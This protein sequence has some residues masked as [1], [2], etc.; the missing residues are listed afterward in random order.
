MLIGVRTVSPEERPRKSRAHHML[1]DWSRYRRADTTKMQPNMT[2]TQARHELVTLDLPEFFLELFDGAATLHGLGLDKPEKGLLWVSE[3]A[4]ASFTP[5]FE[6]GGQTYFAVRETTG[7]QYVALDTASPEIVS[8][9]GTSFQ[10]V[11]AAL[12]MKWWDDERNDILLPLLAE[13]LEFDFLADLLAEIGPANGLPTQPFQQWT[14]D[15]WARCEAAASETLLP[16]QFEEEREPEW[17]WDVA[18]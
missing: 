13:W 5:I 4:A 8:V 14:K 7:H 6:F 3:T 12:F 1:N 11:L 10:C 17:Q 15:F 9:L 16:L 2:K 18:V